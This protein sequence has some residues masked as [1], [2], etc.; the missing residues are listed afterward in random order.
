MVDSLYNLQATFSKNSFNKTAIILSP[1]LFPL[2]FFNDPQGGGRK[3]VL[4]L[5]FICFLSILNNLIPQLNKR[6]IYVIWSIFYPL[7]VLSNEATFFFLAPYLFFN[8]FLLE[9][10]S[11]IK[12]GFFFCKNIFLKYIKLILPAFFTLLY[13]LFLKAFL[14]KKSN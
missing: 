2:F 1:I 7:L 13:H 9:F 3:E 6:F 14:I 4:A 5:I 12:S 11:K 10:N 8:I